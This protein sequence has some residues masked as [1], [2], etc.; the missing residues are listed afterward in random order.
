MPFSA[1]LP[2]FA[3]SLVLLLAVL[4]FVLPCRTVRADDHLGS[5]MMVW[6]RLK[7]AS[8]SWHRHAGSDP[9][10]LRFIR[11]DAKLNIDPVWHSADV[12]KIDQMCAYP[13]LF[14]EGLH[15]VV[16]PTGL[17]NLKEYYQRGGFIFIDSCINTTVN[18]DPDEFLQAQIDTIHSILPDARVERLPDDHPIYHNCFDMKDGLPH[19]YMANEYNPQWAKHGLYAVYSGNRLISIISLSGLQCGWDRMN[20]DPDHVTNCMKMMVNIYVYALTH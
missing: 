5:G 4:S 16:D 1:P 11:D 15:H 17:A 18:P 9:Y 8:L 2:R 3:K 10:L 20:P 19:T 12:E 13:F 14:S 6:A 7:T